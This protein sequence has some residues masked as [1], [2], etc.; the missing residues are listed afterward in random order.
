MTREK[1]TVRSDRSRT[2]KREQERTGRH[3]HNGHVAAV[4]ARYSTRFQDSIDDQIRECREWAEDNGYEVTEEY[5]FVDR[6]TRGGSSKRS[7][8]AAMRRVIEEGK[9]N[10][11]VIFATSRLF[12]KTYRALQ[13]VHEEIVE[14]GIRCVFAKSGI[15]TANK[16]D[17]ETRLHVQS[18]VDEFQ[19]RS[20]KAH[21]Q[22]A[23]AGLLLKGRVFGT[24]SYGYRGE[25]IPGETTR[26]GR[27]ARMIAVDPETSRWVV[28]IFDWYVRERMSTS[29]VVRRLNERNAPLPPRCATKRWTYL[30]VK[31]VLSNPR[32]RGLWHYG[33]TEAKWIS[34]K[35]YVR[36]VEREEPLQTR[37]FEDLQIIDDETWYRAQEL[38]A[39]NPHNAGRKPVDGD[40]KRRPLLLNG[41]LRCAYHDR[42]LVVGGGGGQSAICP[43]CKEDGKGQ[44]YSLLNRRLAVETICRKIAE[45]IRGDDTLVAR[46][47]ET[48]RKAAEDE[49]RPDEGRVDELEAQWTRLS[50]HID[51]VL[52]QFAETEEDRRESRDKVEELRRQ[53]A[54][55]N[56]EIAR[57]TATASAPVRVPTPE[58][59]QGSL[60]GLAAVLAEAVQGDD[61]EAMAYARRIIEIATGGKILV[62]QAGPRQPQRGWLRGGFTVD[63]VKLVAGEL[64]GRGGDG[65]GVEVEVEFR[66]PPIREQIADQ[67]KTL[68]DA[69][70][71][72][73]QIAKRIGRSRSM[74]TKA[75]AFWHESRGLPAPDGRRHVGRLKKGPRLAERIADR[76]MALVRE[77]VPLQDIAAELGVSRNLVTEAIRIW[78]EKRNLPVPDGRTLRKLRSKRGK[79]RR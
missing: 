21:I 10:A 25:E 79:S 13:F 5:V 3:A 24:L 60:T 77:Y 63:V 67:A 66:K 33:R 74:V 44:L 41:L 23:H 9:V 2:E 17:W 29:A 30:A 28:S 22:A 75:L 55:V 53:R 57:L 46:I 71:R 52:D 70:L 37:Q 47:I 8:L 48:C 26:S 78:H 62:Y 15:D 12:R 32:Y 61:K 1:R 31:T 42:P 43:V 68:W 14:R 58:Q 19:T 36:Q 40:R 34:K 16:D 73:S 69:G 56:A 59:V 51:Q 45:M 18:L 64:G 4:Y 27:P 6:A 72:Y 49:Q 76:V 11:V 35:D 7:G 20:A 39:N 38:T 54:G 65:D 50:Q